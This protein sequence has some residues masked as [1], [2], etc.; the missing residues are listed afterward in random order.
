MTATLTVG[1]VFTT[2]NRYQ[3]SV[4]TITIASVN[5]NANSP[6]LNAIG[7]IAS[8]PS[9]A[10]IV[11]GRKPRRCRPWNSSREASPT[12]AVASTVVA[13]RPSFRQI[14]ASTAIPTPVM[15]RV[16]RSGSTP[17]WPGPRPGRGG[18]RGGAPT[19]TPDSP[20]GRILRRAATSRSKA[21]SSS[22]G[23]LAS[24]PTF[25]VSSPSAS[26]DS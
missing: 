1:R 4:K 23:A 10:R 21:V 3:S 8:E 9:T 24:A 22:S 19:R 7:T 11:A 15:T 25:V 17:A 13:S 18:R 26:I 16:V 20:R 12:I 5:G 14:S 2:S 6:R